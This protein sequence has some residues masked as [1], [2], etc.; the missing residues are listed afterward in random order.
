M[1]FFFFTEKNQRM[2]EAQKEKNYFAGQVPEF[3]IRKNE[4]YFST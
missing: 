4:I 1:P 2:N 3:I